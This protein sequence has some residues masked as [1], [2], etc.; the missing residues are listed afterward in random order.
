M[1]AWTDRHCRAF[2]RLLT[3]RTRLYTEMITTGALIHGDVPKHLDF[4]PQEHPVALQLGGSDP[5][6]LAKATAI[7]VRWGYAEINLNC[8]CPSDR[9]QR[10]AFGACLMAHPLLVADGV[11]AM[12][13]AAQ[14][15]PITVKHRL[16]IDR[17]ESYG[18]VRDFVGVVSEAGCK[19]F[20]VHARNAWLD[21]LSP[22]DNRDVPPLRYHDAHQ[23]KR[24][25]DALTLVINGGLQSDQQIAQHLGPMDGVMVG[26][27]AYHDPWMMRH[28]DSQFFGESSAIP[29]RDE[30]EQG[31]V[32]YMTRQAVHGI[33]WP[34]IARHMLGLRNGQ[35]GARRWRQIWSD[36]SLKGETPLEVSC[37]ARAALR[38]SARDPALADQGV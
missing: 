6:D 18:F 38:A 3:K 31:M 8:G 21:G 36:Q 5:A 4:D 30:V 1:M 7:G 34:S 28:W 10:G 33:A 19:T 25:F 35:P 32:D 17:N 23:L 11:K 24:D 16:G 12:L 14:G 15:V 9:V 22:K 2:H 27:A 26:R 29:S 37:L 20:I 13:D